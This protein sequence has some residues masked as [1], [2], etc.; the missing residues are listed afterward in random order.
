MRRIAFPEEMLSRR[1]SIDLELARA[2]FP[3]AALLLGLLG[4]RGAFNLA[5]ATVVVYAMRAFELPPWLNG[6]VLV[7]S[8]VLAWGNALS[9]YSRVLYYDIVAHFLVQLLI[10]P[11]LLYLVATAP[12]ISRC[13]PF[14]VIALTFALGL[15]VGALWEIAEWFSDGT[16]GTNFVKGEADT[17][18]DLIADAC[19]ALLGGWRFSAID[20]ALARSVAP[21][22]GDSRS[23]SG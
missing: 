2:T 3:V 17:A 18:T 14:Q 23:R 6:N 9:L 19:G 7:A 8:G 4:E 13:T 5:L 11:A 10:A 12:I 20:N 16:D 1:A 22:F 15:A 21:A